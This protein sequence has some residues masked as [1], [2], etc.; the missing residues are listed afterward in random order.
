MNFNITNQLYILDFLSFLKTKI[1]Q[2]VK[3]FILESKNLGPVSILRLSFSGT[4][5]PM[6]KIRRSR[7][8]LIFNMGIS[9]LVRRHIYIETDPSSLDTISVINANDLMTYGVI[10]HSF[11]LIILYYVKGY[12]QQKPYI[13]TSNVHCFCFVMSNYLCKGHFQIVAQW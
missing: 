8:R 10:S 1:V 5:I 11:D 4:G 3:P 9:I 6:L 7:D 13:F 2:V 12:I